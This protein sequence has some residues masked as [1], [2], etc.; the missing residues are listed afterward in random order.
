M[1]LTDLIG[2]AKFGPGSQI[3]IRLKEKNWKAILGAIENKR[4]PEAVYL[5]LETWVKPKLSIA[6]SISLGG[7]DA[8]EA[9]KEAIKA[10]E[11]DLKRLKTQVQS[12]FDTLYFDL[13]GVIFTYDFDGNDV[14]ALP[15]K[16]QFLRIE[17]NIDTVNDIDSSGEPAPNH[18]TGKVE[19]LHFES[20]KKPA[21][22]AAEK[23]LK[24]PIFSHSANVEFQKTKRG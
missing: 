10:F 6:K 1:K 8:K 22:E 5:I 19:Y 14:T 21:T 2:E 17:I 23:I 12:F 7:I 24:L 13:S 4:R 16:A 9:A 18:K 3:Q 15:N 20:F 11:Q